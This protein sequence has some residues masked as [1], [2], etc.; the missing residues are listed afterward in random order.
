MDAESRWAGV[1]TEGR[2]PLSVRHARVSDGQPRHRAGPVSCNALLIT[3]LTCALGVVPHGAA[4]AQEATGDPGAEPVPP[5]QRVSV[6]TSLSY[7][8][9]G[10]QAGPGAERADVIAI[11]R[12]RLVY[13]RRGPR[14]DASLDAAASFVEFARGTQSGGLR[15]DI[16]GALSAQV[17]ESWF[18]VD[19]AGR[20]RR[21]E[22]DPFSM[23][24][25]EY[26]GANSRTET[27]LRLSPV[28]DHT[29]GSER[30]L[31]A[32][33]D[34]LVQNNAAGDTT[35]VVTNLTA[36]T[37]E[38]LPR[39]WGVA[40]DLSR[41]TSEASGGADNRYTL[42]SARVR[43][44]AAQDER[45]KLGVF[46]G[47]ERSDYYLSSYTDPLYGVFL[48]WNPGS[49]TQLSTTV[50]HRFFGL[51][52]NLDFRHRTPHL[53]MAL[54]YSRVPVTSSRTIGLLDGS[55][56]I[57]QFLDAILT[58]RYPDS[59]ARRGAVDEIIDGRGLDDRKS[60]RVT[61]L[62]DYPQLQTQWNAKLSWLGPRT[63]MTLITYDQRTRQL[64]RDGDPLP[65]ASLALSDAH[66]RGVEFRWNRRLTRLLSVNMF[67]QWSSIEGLGAR[68]GLE[69]RE[70]RYRIDVVRMLSP[71]TDVML[72][73]QHTSFDTNAP[74]AE[75]VNEN[76]L[77][78]GLVHRFQ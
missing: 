14:L 35:T 5:R 20:V 11:V 77:L 78:F 72:G 22:Q 2:S 24:S 26:G 64:E 51:G 66:Q 21:S 70:R 44:T 58:T 53:A 59:D 10:N 32:R 45:L 28:V 49:R 46:G 29:F 6:E 43:L 67:G 37:L 34:T 17:V 60:D 56:D 3:V 54:S 76:I 7:T 25:G 39:P 65:L 15:P 42:S 47:I 50:E 30:R 9:N 62:A 1:T 63:V 12:P 33:N 74:G 16:S 38:H 13:E 69:S 48:D 73:L 41:L 55:T 27:L 71:R 8:D 31:L 4:W 18:S 68:A 61:I 57:R 52:G 23:Q 19:V 36:L 40:L 75:P